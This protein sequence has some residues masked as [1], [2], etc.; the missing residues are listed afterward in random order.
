MT[1]NFEQALAGLVTNYQT[2]QRRVIIDTHQEPR[3]DEIH[4]LLTQTD[5]EG[6][7]SVITQVS[8]LDSKEPERMVVQLF[9]SPS[10]VFLKARGEQ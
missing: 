8:S 1:E 2:K 6:K 5:P 7:F 9:R 4:Q 10:R 3:A